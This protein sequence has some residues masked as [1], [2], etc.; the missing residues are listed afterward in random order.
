M[1]IA[2]LTNLHGSIELMRITISAKGKRYGRRVLRQVKRWAFEEQQAHHPP[3]AP[4]RTNGNYRRKRD[5]KS[6]T[7][8][9]SE[10]LQCW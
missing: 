5:V 9:R 6:R 2:G 7:E 1:I 8:N 3:F 10:T 4:C